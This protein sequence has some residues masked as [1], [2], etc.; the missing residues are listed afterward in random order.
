MSE[1]IIEEHCYKILRWE[2]VC[3]YNLLLTI[4]TLSMFGFFYEESWLMY[5]IMFLFILFA[6]IPKQDD[7]EDVLNELNMD[8]LDQAMFL[9]QKLSTLKKVIII[10]NQLCE[11]SKFVIQQKPNWK[12][13]FYFYI[14][15]RIIGQII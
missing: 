15:I 10:P 5:P 8:Q 9:E 7:I 6:F 13:W 12:K 3:S 2:R 1:H 4:S 14:K 11:F